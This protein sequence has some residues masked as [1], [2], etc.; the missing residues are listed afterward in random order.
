[1]KNFLY[2]LIIGAAVSGVIW[3]TAYHPGV[4]IDGYAYLMIGLLWAWLMSGYLVHLIP[5]LKRL[6]EKSA[7][8]KWQGSYYEFGGVHLRFYL[9]DEVVWTAADDLVRVVKPAIGEREFGLMGD[10]YGVIPGQTIKGIR[11][12]ALLRLL[13]LRTNHRRTDPQMKKFK[14]WLETQALPNVKRLRSSA[15]T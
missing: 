10:A 4:G 8:G 13:E 2:R 6:A 7:I 3:K 1:M 5:E 9:D 12:D 14:L 11:E 15:A